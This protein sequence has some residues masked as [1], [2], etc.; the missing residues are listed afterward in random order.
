[1]R[2]YLERGR[3]VFVTSKGEGRHSAARFA[4]EFEGGRLVAAAG[5]EQLFTGPPARSVDL[6]LP[7][8]PAG[9]DPGEIAE[10]LAAAVRYWRRPALLQYTAVVGTRLISGLTLVVQP[11]PV[12][13]WAVAGQIAAETGR[14]IPIG[15]SG[16]RSGLPTL[17]SEQR[18]E[19]IARIVEA[20]EHAEDARPGAVPAVL[21]SRAS[22]I[23]VHEAVGHFAEAPHDA[24]I[25]TCHRLGCRIAGER[26][27]VFDDPLAPDGRAHYEVDDDG[28]ACLGRTEVVRQGVLVGQLHSLASAQAVGGTPTA[29]GRAA[30]A[31]QPSIPRMSNLV[32]APGATSEQQMIENLHRGLYVHRLADGFSHGLEISAQVILSEWVHRGRRTGRYV[33]GGRVTGKVD[34]LTQ[35]VEVGDTSMFSDNALC[36]KARQILFD[37]G[38]CAPAMR[39]SALTISQ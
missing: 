38:T 5:E 17:R 14:M 23:L 33:T 6:R 7:P 2:V 36:G 11:R 10:A 24:S 26:V 16:Q 29:N 4:A 30:S 1:M 22:A 37:V 8:P 27:S 12:A 9:D 35:V 31:W 3:S 28:V 18:L 34:V 13:V 19:T 39:L 15:W 20:V 32:C 25:D 21:A